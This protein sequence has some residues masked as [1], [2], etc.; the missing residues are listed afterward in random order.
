MDGQ[1][2]CVFQVGAFKV[3]NQG[4]ERW[5][6]GLEWGVRWGVRVLV[7][8]VEDLDSIPRTHLVAHKMHREIDC[9][10]PFLQFQHL[11]G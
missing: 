4:P 11:G 7:A 6:S 10:G 5:L 2:H 1:G 3:H 9:A 8:L